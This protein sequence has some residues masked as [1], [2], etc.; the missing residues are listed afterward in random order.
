ME[1]IALI[2][3]YGTLPREFINEAKRLGVDVIS[4]GVKGITNFPTDYS[5]PIGKV[6]KLLK[7]LE[8]EKAYSIVMLGKFEHKLAITDLISLDTKALEI[9]R[10]SP[11]RRPETLLKTFVGVLEQE[12]F[13]FIDPFPFLKNLTAPE[14]VLT[15]KEPSEEAWEDCKFAFPIAKEIASLDIG[16]TIVVKKKAIVAVE[17]MEG[18]QETI[19]R[20]GKVGGKG[21]RVVKVARK[22]Q[23][24]RF[25]TPVV[26][27][28]TVEAMKRAGAD[29]LF[30]EAGKVLITDRE[31]FFKKAN[32]FKIA[33]AGYNLKAEDER[34]PDRNRN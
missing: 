24:F 7:I 31:N 34:S 29:A 16:Q 11:D 22:K 15:K 17:A 26:G 12:G 19:L 20:G 25:D 27:P 3:G 5:L 1:K 18:T 21:T 14:G 13:K 28:L 8:K 6:G 23:D 30:V 4:I 33:V 9:L 2:A 10:K 32:S